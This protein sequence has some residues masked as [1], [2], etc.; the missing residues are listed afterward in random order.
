MNFDYRHTT[1]HLNYCHI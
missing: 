1:K